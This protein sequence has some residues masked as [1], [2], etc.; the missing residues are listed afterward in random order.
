MLHAGGR[1]MLHGI[2]GLVRCR[3]RL[4][5][6]KKMENVELHFMALLDELHMFITQ[7]RVKFL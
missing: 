5:S 1:T 7:L 3:A 4:W 6:L 2:P